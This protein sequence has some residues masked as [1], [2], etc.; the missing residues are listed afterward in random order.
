MTLE[1]REFL[2]LAGLVAAGATLSACTPAYRLIADSLES[3][4]IWLQ[5]DAR[6][7][8]ILNRLTY[9]PTLAERQRAAAIGVQAWIE[10]QLDPASLPD[11]RS[12]LAVRP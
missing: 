10:E 3:S 8:R 9:G 12:D 7:F 2:K 5:G 6:A 1:R 4:A 11:L